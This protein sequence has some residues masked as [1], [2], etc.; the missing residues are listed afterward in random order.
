MRQ[1]QK[2]N[3]ARNKNGRKP[4][5]PSINRVYESSGPEGKVRGTP[6]Q[7][8]EKY[9][10]LARDKATAGDR[11]LAE[12]FLQHAEH[13]MRILTA[14]Q[15]T[16]QQHRR[17]EREE[18]EAEVD[19]EDVDARGDAGNDAMAVIDGDEQPTV[20]IVATPES[21]SQPQRQSRRRN[22]DDGDA[23]EGSRRRPR[24]GTRKP[25]EQSSEDADAARADA[26]VA[27]AATGDE[28]GAAAPAEKPAP[29]RSRSRAQPS[30]LDVIDTPEGGGEES[31]DWPATSAVGHA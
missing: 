13:Y 6:Q 25:R 29:R 24:R 16:Q 5:G 10:S 4:S 26:P 15:A 1:S 12:S 18:E 21:M 20:D 28:G 9:Q 23:G 22:D 14:A 7:I 17:D 8:I 30:G 27:E 11:V 19:R 31:D 3:R 2:G